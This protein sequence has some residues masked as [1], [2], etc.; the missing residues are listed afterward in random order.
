MIDDEFGELPLLELAL[1]LDADEVVVAAR[2][3]PKPDD[4][5]DRI[6]G[7][8]F[9][10]VGRSFVVVIDLRVMPFWN[11]TIAEVWA[12]GLVC[13]VLWDAGYQADDFD[14]ER[15]RKAATVL[16]VAAPTTLDGALAVI[17]PVLVS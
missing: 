7:A 6:G 3:D 2:R 11:V 4:F 14:V 8:L 16:L 1:G 12:H 5:L 15:R 17:E 13:A 9:A 10:R